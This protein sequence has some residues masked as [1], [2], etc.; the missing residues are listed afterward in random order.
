MHGW[1]A[2]HRE[3]WDDELFRKKQKRC[4]AFAWIDMINMCNW[5]QKTWD[6]GEGKITIPRG[7]FVTSIRQLSARWGWNEVGTHRYVKVLVR[8]NMVVAKAERRFTLITVVN[9]DKYQRVIDHREAGAADGWNEVGTRAL[10]KWNES[11]T[12]RDPK[13]ETT[14]QVTINNKQKT[15]KRAGENLVYPEALSSPECRAAHADWMEFRRGIKKPLT[16]KSHQAELLHWAPLG[17]AVFIRAIR[18]TIRLGYQG[19]R[20]YD[21]ERS[22]I[23]L[24]PRR[25]E[26]DRTPPKFVPEKVLNRDT[27]GRD[28]LTPEQRAKLESLVPMTSKV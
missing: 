23:G 1:F 21:S 24:V 12:H 27:K 8:R 11:G 16:L 26:P 4:W 5:K 14:E 2:L 18:A 19:L 17:A 20:D 28:G 9:Y 13:V 10:S 22:Q 3:L 25:T 7:S 15:T 6:S